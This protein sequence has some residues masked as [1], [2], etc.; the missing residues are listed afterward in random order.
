MKKTIKAHICIA[1]CLAFLFLCV[2]YASF[3]DRLEIYGK[4]DATAP[5]GIFIKS[6]SEISTS[7]IDKNEFSFIAASTNVMNKISRGS[8]DADGV[9]IYEV[10]VYNNTNT[11][12]YYPKYPLNSCTCTECSKFEGILPRSYREPHRFRIREFRNEC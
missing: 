1:F 4:T 12:Y 10:T 2:G 5:E 11:T 7:N 8:D 9:V 6:I 3:S